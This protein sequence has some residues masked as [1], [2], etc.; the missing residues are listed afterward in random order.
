[1]KQS[2]DGKVEQRI[3]VAEMRILRLLIG[4]ASIV[5]RIKDKLG[6]VLR[7]EETEAVRYVNEM[8]FDCKRGRGRPKKSR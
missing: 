6:Y 2:V 1:M 7:S 5:D 8:F 3:C 4:E